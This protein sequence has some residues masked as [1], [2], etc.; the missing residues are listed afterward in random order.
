[1]HLQSS[2]HRRSRKSWG[3]VGV[4]R[5]WYE[6]SPPVMTQSADCTL[7]DVVGEITF[8][9]RFGFLDAQKDI[10]GAI[11]STELMMV[12]GVSMG[13]ALMLNTLLLDNPFIRKLTHYFNLTDK[14][15]L[16]K[17]AM[18]A[19][20]K[21]EENPDAKHDMVSVWFNNLSKNSATMSHN[22]IKAG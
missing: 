17:I 6:R 20:A 1:M 16:V 4:G 5:V 9:A 22:E 8:S 13:Y 14:M 12:Y 19:L 3:N 15:H 10:G 21:R 11:A 7:A 2:K 18:A